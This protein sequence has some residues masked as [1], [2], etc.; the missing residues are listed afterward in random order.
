MDNRKIFSHCGYLFISCITYQFSKC[1]P[2]LYGI[3]A[4]TN[5]ANS[6]NKVKSRSVVNN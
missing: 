1:K 2:S 3:F 6:E 5:Q 4:N